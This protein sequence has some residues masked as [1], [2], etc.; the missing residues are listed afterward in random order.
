MP[1]YEAVASP[2]VL[3]LIDGGFHCGFL[4]S[5]IIFCDEGSIAREAQL[6][7][8]WSR[9]AAFF[10]QHL[11]NLPDAYERLVAPAAGGPGLEILTGNTA[12]AP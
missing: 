3:L 6:A 12:P 7:L 4:D 1:I 2:R 8:T 10:D 11:R 9:A 5:P